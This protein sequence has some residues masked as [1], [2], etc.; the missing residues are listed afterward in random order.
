MRGMWVV[1]VGAVSVVT[2][3]AATL[4]H[5]LIAAAL[6]ALVIGAL[7][8]RRSVV[9]V[10]AAIVLGLMIAFPVQYLDG[11]GGLSRGVL[12]AAPVVTA[13]A[14]ARTRQR[15]RVSARTPAAFAA[16]YAVLLTLVTFLHRDIANLN[17]L[18]A[19]A[20]PAICIAVLLSA[21]NDK[22]TRWV[23][24][25]VILVGC[26][27]SIYGVAEMLAHLAPIWTDATTA[28]R[29]SQILPGFT[30]AQ[31]TLAHPLPL[32]LLSIV[33]IALLLSR[34][35]TDQRRGIIPGVTILT[36]GVI[37]T[38][39]RSALVL[40]AL[41]LAFSI[42]RRAWSILSVAA[43]LGVL[44]LLGLAAG[45]FFSSNVWTNFVRGDSLSHRNGAL[46]AVPRLLQDQ[47][48]G[49]VVFGN[50]YFSAPSLFARGLLQQGSFFAIDNQLVT[51]LVETGLLGVLLL[52]VVCSIIFVRAARYRMLIFTIVAFFFT[53]DL[54]SWP[55]A[56]TLFAF[57]IALVFRRHDAEEFPPLTPTRPLPRQASTVR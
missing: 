22:Q 18:W 52:S 31:G 38:G 23:E 32:A 9:P 10:A 41:L 15:P 42:G 12:Y 50:G 7:L 47:S 16:T 19:T 51:T 25:F 49:S 30:R 17:L 48:I 35:Y 55:S 1:P 6:I 27:E 8:P 11:F 53:F 21:S 54:L 36:L 45:G 57:S 44:G 40:I 4:W 2:A 3:V 26:A 24:N 34:R 20:V 37:A 39:S 13:L 43:G 14:L 33:G 56:A 29:A 5:P 28:G 46:D